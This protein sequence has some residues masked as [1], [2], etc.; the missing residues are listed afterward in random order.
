MGAA[1]VKAGLEVG[2]NSKTGRAKPSVSKLVEKDEARAV[3]PIF[4]ADTLMPDLYSDGLFQ[5]E[6]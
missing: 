3:D 2:A 5:R 6:G 4:I 1:L